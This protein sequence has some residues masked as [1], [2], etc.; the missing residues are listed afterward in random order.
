MR[1]LGPGLSDPVPDAN[2]IWTFRAALTRAEIAGRPAIEVLF[3]AY[4]TALRQAGVMALGGQIIDATV[5]AASKQRNT[6]A[7]EAE[8]ERFRSELHRVCGVHAAV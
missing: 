4:D 7:E 3:A 1:F 2:T 5:V 8:L 6:E